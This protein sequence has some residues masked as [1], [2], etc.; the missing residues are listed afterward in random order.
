MFLQSSRI[1]N[2][3]RRKD[4]STRSHKQTNKYIVKTYNFSGVISSWHKINRIQNHEKAS[5]KK[6][7]IRHPLQQGRDRMGLLILQKISYLFIIYSITHKLKI[8]QESQSRLTLIKL[9]TLCLR[10]LSRI[11][12]Y[13]KLDVLYVGW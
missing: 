2:A 7:C 12:I 5:D 13:F 11:L 8:F 9:L 10:S 1:D 3:T 4:T 6:M